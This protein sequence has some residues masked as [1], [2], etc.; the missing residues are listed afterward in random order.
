MLLVVYVFVV[1]GKTCKHL[2]SVDYAV[3]L[4]VR[5]NNVFYLLT[6]VLNVVSKGS[7]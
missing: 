1:S 2:N 7:C 4:P 6:H 5:K 3:D